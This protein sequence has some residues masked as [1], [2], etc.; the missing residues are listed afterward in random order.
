MKKIYYI[1]FLYASIYSYSQ[2]T[3][4]VVG[5]NLTTTTGQN[6]I[7][8]GVNYPLINQGSISLSNPAS[9]QFYIDEVAKTGANSVRIPWYTNGQN[10]RDIPAQGGTAGTVNG[11]VTNGHLSNII[12]YCIT[13]GMTPILSIHD[14]SFITCNTNWTHFNSAVM[15]FWT[16]PA[17]LSLIEINKAHL[18][19]NLANEFDYVRWSGNQ[20]VALTN[21]K[22]NY[23]AAITTLRNAGVHVPI[24]IDAPDCG[25]SSTELLSIA[26]SM[27]LSDVRHNLIFSAHAYWGG[28]ASTLAQVQTKLNEALNTNVC[29]VLGEVAKNQDNGSCGS[30]DLSALYPQILTEACARNIGW[31]AWAFSLDCSSARQMTTNSQYTTL[32]IFGNDIVN[33]TIYGLKSTNGCGATNFLSSSDFSLNANLCEIFPNPSNGNFNIKTKENIKKIMAFDVLGK[34]VKINTLSNN[35]F[36]IEKVGVYF[37]K[38]EFDN[39]TSIYKKIILK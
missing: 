3:M 38:I 11:Y 18:I 12:A 30:L 25:Q 2:G 28:Y 31:L 24:M 21:F 17:V 36:S 7:I 26:E 1:L 29:Y 9:Y 34:E 16:S 14:D 4:Q 35:L 20:A 5:K 22:N 8:R 6:F 23:N 13:K 39:Q 37:I 33:N 32:T 19:I 15:S 27:N 10:W